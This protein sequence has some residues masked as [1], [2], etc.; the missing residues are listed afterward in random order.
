MAKGIALL[1]LAAFTLAGCSKASTDTPVSNLGTTV[2]SFPI[3]NTEFKNCNFH[4][5]APSYALNSAITPNYISCDEG[6]AKSVQLLSATA[7]PNGLSFD[8]G[9]LSLVGTPTTAIAATPYDFY[10]EN[11]AGYLILRLNLTVK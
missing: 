2:E 9:T 10:I 7:L 1:I 4:V 3:E 5:T 11:E 8:L 6:V